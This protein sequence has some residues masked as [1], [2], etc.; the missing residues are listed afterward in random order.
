MTAQPEWIADNVALAPYTTM[1]VGGPARWFAQ[2]GTVEEV[3]ATLNFAAKR[4]VPVLL[5][6]GGSNLVVAD[7]GVEAVVM[8]LR[9]DCEFGFVRQE[10]DPLVWTVGA[11]APLPGL[12]TALQERGVAGLEHLAGI[13]GSAGGAAAMNAGSA[14]QGFGEV[15][16]Q[17]RVMDS[18][19]K[20]HIWTAKELAFGYRHSALS[21][22]GV[23][24][25]GFSLLLSG[26]EEPEELG[27]RARER[28]D[29]KTATQPLAF[30]S[31]GC[32]FRNPHDTSAGR[33]LDEAGCKGMVEGGAEVS[34]LHANFIINA[35][36]ATA[37]DVAVLAARMRDA[38]RQRCGVVLEPEITWW[39]EEKA[40]QNL[41]P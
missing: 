1:R 16:M 38:V 20:E 21:G 11:A 24:A 27:R 32:I 15:V 10:A 6:G 26:L 9:R 36:G 25:L 2:P 4:S 29:A 35:A 12:V 13:P 3:A 7:A 19:G 22:G 5:L 37:R 39:G 31:A 30:A 41:Q 34:G 17:A 40:W 14:E 23:I 8:R 18:S 28:R 33:L